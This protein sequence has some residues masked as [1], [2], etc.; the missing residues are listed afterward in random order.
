MEVPRGGV[1]KW[2]APNK[3][4][5]SQE[6]LK[7]AR[8]TSEPFNM[9]LDMVQPSKQTVKGEVKSLKDILSILGTIRS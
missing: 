2:R 9:V 4:V 5:D 3:Q 1:V 6:M 8:Q 7:D